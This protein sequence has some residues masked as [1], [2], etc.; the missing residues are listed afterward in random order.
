M[1]ALSG[2]VLKKNGLKGDVTVLKRI[3]GLFA[4]DNGP[5]EAD[6]FTLLPSCMGDICTQL[7][8]HL[9]GEQY[10]WKENEGIKTFE[11]LLLSKF[12]MD[13][14]LTT[15]RGSIPDIKIQFYL[16]IMD[17]IL[18][19]MLKRTFPQLEP[20]EI[21]KNR[22]GMYSSIISEN[23]HPKCWLLLAGACTGIDYYSEKDVLTF[24]ASSL[25]LPVLLMHA[26]NSLKMVIKEYKP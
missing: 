4:R 1:I 8:K 22:L 2:R 16:K 23:S 26:Q 17:T 10:R 6:P 15:L 7:V 19:G 11:C 5:T 12:L 24:T 14:A 18:E 9:S 3:K 13:H 25:A 20:S 21:V